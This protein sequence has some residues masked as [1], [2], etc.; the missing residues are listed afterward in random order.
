MLCLC[1]VR[2]FP[3]PQQWVPQPQQRSFPMRATFFWAQEIIHVPID[4]PI[5]E[6]AL[7]CRNFHSKRIKR[8]TFDLPPEVDLLFRSHTQK[9]HFN[10]SL[11]Q[12][13]HRRWAYHEL[14]GVCKEF[15][16]WQSAF[17]EPA[18]RGKRGILKLGL[19]SLKT[20]FGILGNL[21]I[22][23]IKQ[24]IAKI[25][26]FHQGQTKLLAT[27]LAHMN[28]TI[29]NLS[30]K[31]EA[32]HEEQLRESLHLQ[33]FQYIADIRTRALAIQSGLQLA[34][35]GRLSPSLVNITTAGKILQAV[36]KFLKKGR[37]RKISK[38][39]PVAE[40]AIELYDCPV[41]IVAFDGQ[42]QLWIH[43]PI[44]NKKAK[45]FQSLT[46]PFQ[47]KGAGKETK[48]LRVNHQRNLIAVQEPF[49]ATISPNQLRKCWKI[50]EKEFVCHRNLPLT[51]DTATSCAR[52]LFRSDIQE[53]KH[54]C[55][56]HEVKDFTVV[57]LN[58]AFT[59]FSPKAT[60]VEIACPGS[61]SSKESLRAGLV[62]RSL[63]PGCSAW[64]EKFRLYQPDTLLIPESIVVKLEWGFPEFTKLTINSMLGRRKDT[65][66]LDTELWTLKTSLRELRQD[67]QFHHWLTIGA[68]SSA[69]VALLGIIITCV[70]LGCVTCQRKFRTTHTP[71]EN[72]L[73]APQIPPPFS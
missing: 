46:V 24:T 70:F 66:G 19:Q 32:K 44:A 17:F 22:K 33:F 25:P 48:I 57:Q 55:E 29:L 12:Q 59:V 54:S 30:R 72:P 36:N 61:Q 28:N 16:L 42:I 5:S 63:D 68:S 10:A 20:V 69:G 4:L 6:I 71:A 67:V 7:S 60:S 2:P 27:Q 43:V 14:Y 11:F 52:A 49:F 18:A 73:Y 58:K 62:T 26:W 34:R 65:N 3:S 13:K 8:E 1:Y 35:H 50:R 38:F 21:D 37:D 51:R 23:Q 15:S 9:Q 64:S 39:Q 31:L 45:L 40:I 56:L 41:S 47:W 53:I